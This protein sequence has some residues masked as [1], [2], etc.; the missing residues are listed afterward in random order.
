MRRVVSEA[1]LRSPA[2]LPFRQAEWAWDFMVCGR[3]TRCT[4]PHHRRS[5]T[6]RTSPDTRRFG[7]PCRRCSGPVARPRRWVG[8]TARRGA[9]DSGLAAPSGQTDPGNRSAAHQGGRHARRRRTARRSGPQVPAGARSRR[10]RDATR[11]SHV[12]KAE[13]R[14]G[15]E[16]RSP[17][18]VGK[19]PGEQ[20]VPT[21]AGPARSP[22]EGPPIPGRET[23]LAGGA[24]HVV[25]ARAAYPIG[26]RHGAT[27]VAA[28]NRAGRCR[29]DGENAARKRQAIPLK[30][31]MAT[32]RGPQNGGGS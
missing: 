12:V 5:P 16:T 21:R 27:R 4:G 13:R 25:P 7:S 29:R 11:S 2:G 28:P 3:Q 26:Q 23:Q 18:R 32:A 22:R 30:D 31:R 19:R 15:D 8:E 1:E 14:E 17:N 10:P 24:G 6:V 20:A 9:S